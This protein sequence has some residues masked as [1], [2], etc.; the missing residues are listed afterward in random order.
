MPTI[1]LEVLDCAVY[2]YRDEESARAGVQVGGSG[3]LVHIPVPGTDQAATFYAVTNAH[4][5]AGGASCVRLNTA[6]GGHAAIPL[7]DDDWFRHPDGDDLVVAEIELSADFRFK[8]ISPDSFVEGSDLT[9]FGVGQE[10][11][12]VGRHVN[13]EGRQRNQPTARFGHIAQLPYEPVRNAA[14]LQ[15]EAF[16]V[17]LRSLS[18]YSGAPVFVYRSRPDL[19]GDPERWVKGFEQRF[20]GIDCG[21]LPALGKVLDATRATPVEPAMWAEQNS[22]IATVIPAWS[23]ARLLFEDDDVLAAREHG[24]N[25]WLEAHGGGPAAP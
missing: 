25:A 20:L 3:F 8:A 16:L 13:H 10:V 19:D 18:G 11:Y 1:P 23:L 5:V 15:Q 14:G 24:E 6:D 9:V 21:H 22:G 17:D 7:K 4:V 2:L 12:M